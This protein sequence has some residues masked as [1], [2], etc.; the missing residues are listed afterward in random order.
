MRE[1][2]YWFWGKLPQLRRHEEP[3][4]TFRAIEM[5]LLACAASFPAVPQAGTHA[6]D[7]TL[8]SSEPCP[9]R[10]TTRYA[11]YVAAVRRTLDEERK[12]AAEE[13]IVMPAISE[14]RLRAALATPAEFAEHIAYAGFECRKVGYASGGLVIA[15]L[16]W[17]PIDTAGKS[18]PLLIANRGGN[19]D[20]GTM[21]PWLYWG[22]HD[23]LKAGYVV[24]ASQYRGAPG[25]E[26]QDGFG[27]ADLD[28][29]R[30]LL[31][32]ARGLGYVDMRNIFMFGGSRGGMET[33]MLARSGFPLRA[34]A[35]RAGSADEQRLLAERPGMGD[36]YKE[37]VPE[38]RV[39]PKAALARRS[40][41]LWANEIK[42]PTIIFHGTDDWRVDPRDAL[43]VV[44]GLAAARTPYELHMYEGDTHAI[45]LNERDMIARTLAFFERHRKA[46]P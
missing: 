16:L 20:F 43:D 30:A 27:G 9:L 18:F 15:G 21:S 36:E 31:P 12:D 7:G 1:W 4:M 46:T 29:V 25:S 8:L 32:L 14:A 26:G 5:I 13:H 38:Y 34:M 24:L 28:D 37:L 42:V 35:I 17:K 11:D 44:R 23:F 6:E 2:L 10:D 33:Y 19:R 22:W 39:D 45:T 3:D 40:A 41:A